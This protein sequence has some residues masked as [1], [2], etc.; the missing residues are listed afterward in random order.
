MGLCDHA[1]L[2]NLQ[3]DTKHLHCVFTLCCW[4]A[5]HFLVDARMLN[6]N[7]I[8]Y[9]NSLKGGDGLNKQMSFGLEHL[10]VGNEKYTACHPAQIGSHVHL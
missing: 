10:L 9:F 3:L 6:F 4:S 2:N 5:H 8:M 1:L 7:S